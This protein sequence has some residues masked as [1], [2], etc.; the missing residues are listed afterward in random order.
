MDIDPEHAKR[1]F[2]E[3]LKN[4]VRLLTEGAV[5]MVCPVLLAASLNKVQTTS[6]G[7][8]FARGSISP[9]SALTLVAGL[10][11]FLCLCICLSFRI[12]TDRVAHF[13][14]VGSKWLVHLCA[15]LLMALALGILL[16][17]DR[18]HVYYVPIP[19]V[20][21]FFV[22]WR[23]WKMYQHDHGRDAM[24]Y[25]GDQQDRLETSVDFSV[26]VTALLFLGLEGLALEGQSRSA[27]RLRA[28]S[29]VLSFI[30]CL[31]GVLFMLLAT[32]PPMITC[33]A[34]SNTACN[35]IEAMNKFLAGFFALNV[36]LITWAPLGELAW[37]VWIQLLVSLLAWAYESLTNNERQDEQQHVTPATMELTKVISAGFLAVSVPAVSNKSVSGFTCAFVLITGTAVITGILW[38][39]LTDWTPAGSSMI[40]AVNFADRKSVV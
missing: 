34:Q 7:H 9:L 32:V 25:S 10:L 38:R 23:C 6:N 30:A 19:G 29:L 36:F 5:I 14:F 13:L 39:V 12:V 4:R 20:S 28:A 15:L 1:V 37:L 21:I 26:S 2:V 3:K 33:V 31:A 16:L 27:Q 11:S 22:L 17:V 18:K 40:K 35:Y 8:G 24:L